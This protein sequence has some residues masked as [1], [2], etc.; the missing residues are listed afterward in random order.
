MT[1]SIFY[2]TFNIIYVVEIGWKNKYV[3]NNLCLYQ[4]DQVIP[5]GP[6]TPPRSKNLRKKHFSK[7]SSRLQDDWKRAKNLLNFN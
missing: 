1:R 3:I 2:T 6:K 7:W 4:V 5:R